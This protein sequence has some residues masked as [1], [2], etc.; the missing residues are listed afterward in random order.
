MQIVIV[1]FGGKPFSC[2]PLDLEKWMWCVFLGL[3]EL[4]WGQVTNSSVFPLQCLTAF[5]SS[6]AYLFC[7]L[8]VSRPLFDPLLCLLPGP[9]DS[10]H[11]QQQIALPAESRAANSERR[12]TRGGCE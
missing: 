4:V 10:H 1:Q 3:G 6:P 7:T 11:T 8:S 2:Q 5:D 9:G 12:I